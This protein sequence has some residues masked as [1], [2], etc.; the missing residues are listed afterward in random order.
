MALRDSSF[1]IFLLKI[2]CILGLFFFL[3]LLGG[4]SLFIFLRGSGTAAAGNLPG[5][6][7]RKLAEF[8]LLT[9]PPERASP[10]QLNSFLDSLEQKALS[11]E[12]H[13][14]VLKRR[15]SLAG[16]SGFPPETKEA[17]IHAYAGAADRISGKF[18]S[19]EPL[20]VLAAEALLMRDPLA[21]GA[22]GGTLQNYLSRIHETSLLPLA[23]SLHV[24][25][26]KM[27]DPQSAADIPG[28]EALFASI[29]PLVS[30][31]ER[32]Q[33][34]VN[35]GILRLLA[36]DAPGCEAMVNALIAAPGEN[37]RGLPGIAGP[38]APE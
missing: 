38:P 19:S 8:D 17:F 21:G 4:M 12:S 36:G 16:N 34:L 18:P 3:V 14:S 20:A 29:I 1:M 22:S 33:F 24:L 27:T 28:G 25:A 37:R 30:E 32:E 11:V 23:L 5:D 35:Q 10:K 9:E 15:R 2:T 13:L 26:G 31:K 6:F 7:T